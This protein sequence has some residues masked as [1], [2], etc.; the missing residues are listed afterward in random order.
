[1]YGEFKNES[2]IDF[3][4]E[5]N[6]RKMEEALKRVKTELGG[7]YP[8]IIGGKRGEVRNPIESINPSHKGEVVGIVENSSIKDAERALEVAEETFRKWRY[9]RAEDRAEYLFKMADIMRRRR[10][11]LDAWLVYEV[12]KSWLEADGDIAEA[13]DFLEYYGREVIRYGEGGYVTPVAGEKPEMWYIPLGVGVSIP[14]WNFPMSILTGMTAAAFGAG[15]TVIL[16][17]SSDSPVTGAK[18]MEV[19]EEAGVPDGVVNFLPGKGSKIGDVLVTSPK[20]RFITFTGSKA[21]GL[22]IVELASKLSKGQKWI[23]R[24]IAEMGG[25]DTT[26]VDSETDLDSAVNGVIASAYGYQGQKCSACSRVI[27]LGDIYDE[28]VDKL[29]QK[30]KEIKQGPPEDPEHYM[31]A[32][33]NERAYRSIFEY[34]E[35]GKREGKLVL[36]GEPAEG[37]GYYIKPTIIIDLDPKARI[38]QEEIFGPVLAVVPAKNF[39]D[40]L[41][42]AN[43]TDYG[44]TGSVYTRNRE[45]ID[46]AKREFHIGNLY[47]NRKC[48]GALVGAHPFGGFNLS[49]TDT[50]TGS[51]DYLLFFLQAKAI[52][53]KI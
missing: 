20:T 29:V 42:I 41:T 37:D 47:I 15:N 40:A 17:P 13:I 4:R 6:R 48:T 26:I 11:E 53:E 50:K 23:K 43:C 52:S 46:R 25:K 2:I 28:F 36:G 1:M 7:E 32:V 21:V 10:F 35:I 33:I 3:K 39:D 19:V 27:A 38:A 49:G 22:R 45:K 14:P 51:R 34:I 31:G 9:T 18:F 24:V 44:L 12:G 5:E 30:A 16:K 8:N